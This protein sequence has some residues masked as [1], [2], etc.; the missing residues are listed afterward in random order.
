MYVGTTDLTEL[1]KHVNHERYD[2]VVDSLKKHKLKNNEDRQY[3]IERY[4]SVGRGSDNDPE[5]RGL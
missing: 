3:G 4:G 5:A 2:H 1:S